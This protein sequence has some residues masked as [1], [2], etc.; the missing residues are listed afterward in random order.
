MSL[1]HTSDSAQP[2][3]SAINLVHH[4][5][6]NKH[7]NNNNTREEQQQDYTTISVPDDDKSKPHHHH[8]NGKEASHL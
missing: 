5:R 1:I 4:V 3:S 8:R 7:V 6:G 2:S